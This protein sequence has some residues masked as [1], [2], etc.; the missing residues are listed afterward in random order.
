MVCPPRVLRWSWWV[1][2]D[3]LSDDTCDE[4]SRESD[5]GFGEPVRGA[6]FGSGGSR[7]PVAGVS[8]WAVVFVFLCKRNEAEGRS[9]S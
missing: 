7:V 3:D 5:S 8:G 9:R 4:F 2:V 1:V 6:V